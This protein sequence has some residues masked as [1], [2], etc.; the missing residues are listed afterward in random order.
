MTSLRA[1]RWRLVGVFIVLVLVGVG[2]GLIGFH[3]GTGNPAVTWTTGTAYS[4]EQQISAKADGWTYD[5][6]ITVRWSDPL[7]T[8]HDASRPAC[9]PPDSKTHAVKFGWVW[10]STP[11]RGWRE[12]VWVDC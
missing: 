12:V 2:A 8:V 4:A 5:I 7:G 1:I 10:V 9:L 3:F 11:Q 6:P